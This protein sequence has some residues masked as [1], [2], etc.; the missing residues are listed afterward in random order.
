[1]RRRIIRPTHQIFG[2][3][4]QSVCYFHFD[5][6]IKRAGLTHKEVA[7]QLNPSSPTFSKKATNV[8]E[9]RASEIAALYKLLKL[10]SCDQP[11]RRH[12][13][14]HGEN[15]SARRQ[16]A[17]SLRTH[18]TNC[19]ELNF[20][21]EDVF[22]AGKKNIAGGDSFVLYGNNQSGV[23]NQINVNRNGR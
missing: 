4:R 6:A 8:V 16:S 22:N 1:M 5:F 11:R 20:V 21:V 17:D 15:Q 23:G 7:R 3:G 18:P 19:G 14:N 13:D 10:S 9:F 2:R 12:N